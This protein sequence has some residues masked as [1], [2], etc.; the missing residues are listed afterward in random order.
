MGGT[1]TVGLAK[2]SMQYK[3]CLSNEIL[4]IMNNYLFYLQRSKTRKELNE[5]G[6]KSKG[7]RF[8]ASFIIFLEFLLTK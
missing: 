8:L 5:K 6:T 2:C 7:I 3:N 1:Y 4:H